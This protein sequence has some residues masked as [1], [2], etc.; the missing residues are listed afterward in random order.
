MSGQSVRLSVCLSACLYA[1]LLAT[2]VAVV[3]VVAGVIIA[4]AETG[5]HL[6][7]PFLGLFSCC[8]F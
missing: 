4:S 3:V 7:S 1:C 5:Q 2:V 6:A 8:Y